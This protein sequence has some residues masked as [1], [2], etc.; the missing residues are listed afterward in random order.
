MSPNILETQFQ[1]YKCIQ[2]FS[3]PRGGGW[4]QMVPEIELTVEALRNE[5]FDPLEF[6]GT[7]LG[8]GRSENHFAAI[9]KCLIFC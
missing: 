2:L 3:R 7:D 9:K 5:G 6:L 4:A 8:V 1:S